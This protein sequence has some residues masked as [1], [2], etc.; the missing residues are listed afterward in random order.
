MDRPDGGASSLGRRGPRDVKTSRAHRNSD[1][2]LYIYIYMYVYIYIYVL[3]MIPAIFNNDISNSMVML[4]RDRIIILILLITM[5]LGR[6]EPRDVKTSR[7][8][9]RP[10]SA[11]RFWI[12]EGL[13]QAES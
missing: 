11:L 2:K 13:T 4:V 10:I 1:T 7:I 6:R 5:S 9:I 12:S 3:V 8:T